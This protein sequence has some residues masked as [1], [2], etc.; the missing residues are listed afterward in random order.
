MPEERNNE[1][2]GSILLYRGKQPGHSAVTIRQDGRIC[3]VAGWDGKYVRSFIRFKFTILI[4]LPHR[5]RLYSTKTL[6]PLGT[7]AYHKEN[8]VAV[9]FAT[10]Y[11]EKDGAG[12]E[13]LDTDLLS[14]NE[15]ERR[16]RWLVSGGADKRISIWE[17]MRFGAT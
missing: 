15:K 17:L 16:G 14:E 2:N 10:P 6:K 7:L 5:V 3:A 1:R 11:Y 12:G 4:K 9:C 13:S 8:C